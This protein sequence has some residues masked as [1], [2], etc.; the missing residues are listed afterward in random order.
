MIKKAGESINCANFI[1]E[2]KHLILYQTAMAKS[3][4]KDRSKINKEIIKSSNLFPVAGIGASAGG[5]DAFKRLLKA[6]PENSGIA[7]VLVQHLDPTMKA[8]CLNCFKELPT[9]R[10]WKL[11][12]I[13]K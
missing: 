7:Y 3:E 10:Y 9:F 11:Q 8:Y 4:N 13:L 1:K 2:I 12:T 6:I 5:L